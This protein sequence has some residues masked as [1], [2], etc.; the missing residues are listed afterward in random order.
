MKDDTDTQDYGQRVI[1][2]IDEITELFNDGKLSKVRVNSM[3]MLVL[4]RQ[5]KTPDEFKRREETIAR[6]DALLDD[7]Q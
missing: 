3:L 6:L 7:S 5:P 4:C 2:T 1:D